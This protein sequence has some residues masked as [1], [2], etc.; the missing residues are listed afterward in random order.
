MADAN[1][2]QLDIDSV[3]RI[4]LL[5]LDGDSFED[6]LL[7]A[8]GHVD[9]DFDNFNRCKT[10]LMLLQ[11][12]NPALEVA[13]IL[14]QR[15]PDNPAMAVPLVASGSLPLEGHGISPISPELGAALSGQWGVVRNRAE[16]VSR[17]YP[18]KNSDGEI[19]GAL[20][21]LQG[22]RTDI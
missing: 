1:Y 16:G 21:L 20:E 10:S 5:Y 7:D 19:V 4:G 22:P 2:T 11:R 14:W 6:V 18:V 13:A 9:Y 3:A 17:Y 15:R 12:I 8:Y